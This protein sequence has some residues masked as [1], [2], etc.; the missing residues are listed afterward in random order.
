MRGAVSCAKS[1]RAYR[2]NCTVQEIVKFRAW[3]RAEWLWKRPSSCRSP[4]WLLPQSVKNLGRLPKKI[5]VDWFWHCASPIVQAV[6]QAVW[7][8]PDASQS[9]QASHQYKQWHFQYLV[10]RPPSASETMTAL[11]ADPSAMWPTW[12]G[13]FPELWR[14]CRVVNSAVTTFARN[15]RWDQSLLRL[16]CLIGRFRQCTHIFHWVFVHKSLGIESLEILHLPNATILYSHSKDWTVKFP[17][18]G[19]N[20]T[21]LQPLIHMFFHL[22]TVGIRYAELLDIHWLFWFEQDLVQKHFCSAQIKLVPTNALMV[23]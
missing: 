2:R 21:H 17:A 23:L 19:L 8:G 18:A 12:T 14:L 10:Q 22:F 16:N 5:Y 11:L 3:K 7:C 1:E 6:C 20:Y 9:V 13:L 4:V 15:H